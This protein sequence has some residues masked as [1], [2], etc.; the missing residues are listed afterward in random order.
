M[1]ASKQSIDLV[2]NKSNLLDDLLKWAL[3]FGRL[4][5]IIVEI[6]A[7]SAFIWRFSL[8]RQL[9]DLN[10]KIKQEQAIIEAMKPRE[11]EYRNLQQRLATIKQIDST[12]N[13]SYQTL[14]DIVAFTPAEITYNSI[15]VA[16]DEIKIDSNIQSISSL[17]SFINSLKEYPSV[18]SVNINSIQNKS[19]TNSVNVIIDVKLKKGSDEISH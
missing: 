7:F 17:T 18:L 1:Q 14:K 6:V 9:I 3:S 16:N 2:K 12:G 15:T 10:D 5:V 4:L 11:M 13:K 8:D 19:Q